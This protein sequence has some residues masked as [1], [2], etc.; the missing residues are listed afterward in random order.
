MSASS[1]TS[2]RP[3]AEILKGALEVLWL[4][5]TNVAQLLSPQELLDALADGFRLLAKGDVQAP[6]RPE[7]QVPGLGFSLAMP[8]WVEGMNIAVKIVNVFDCNHG[9]GLPSHLALINLFDARTGAPV[10]VMDGTHITAVR[11]AGAAILSVKELARRDARIATVIGAGVQAREHLRLLPLVREFEEIQLVSLVFS[12]AER[13]AERFHGVRA[14]RN[15]EE[16]VRRS[17]VVCLATHSPEPVIQTGWVRPGA[18]VSS[19]GYFP[20]HGEMPR[21]LPRKHK[22]FIETIDSF[23]PPPVG[24]AELQ[25]LDLRHGTCLGEVLLGRKSGRDNPEQ[26]TVYKAM[27]TAMEDLVAA[28]IVYAEAKRRRVGQVVRL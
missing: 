20:P 12:D 11:T 5:E 25:G 16:A 26:V 14:V 4:S 6:A 7:V 19:V 10:C 27:G 28:Q 22:L 18:H 3:A 21:D 17:D 23:S 13:L 1:A 24:C 8:A 15:V 2:A 9:L